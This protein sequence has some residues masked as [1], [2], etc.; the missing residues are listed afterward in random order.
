MNASTPLLECR[1]LCFGY[2]SAAFLGPIELTIQAGECW[3]IVGPNGAGKSTLLRLLGGLLKPGAGNVRLGGRLVSELSHRER[4]KLVS[5]LPQHPPDADDFTIRDVVL[6]G[7]HPHRTFG[8]FESTADHSI[9]HQ[10]MVQTGV[11]DLAD[12]ALASVSGGEAQRAHLA[13]V[14]AQQTPVVLLD[15]PTASLDL[16]HQLG[17]FEV[18]L[19]VLDDR[20][21]AAVVVLHDINMATMFC[22]HIALMHEGRL[23]ASGEPEAVLTAERVESVYGVRLVALPVSGRRNWLI[24]ETYPNSATARLP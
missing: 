5:F 22:S 3:A 11:A 8:L 17:V 6:A 19:R 15:E 10:T 21:S 4:A 14:L 2:D 12:R 18:L 16:K 23:V 13:A 20:S 7:R 24:P 1:D 9:A